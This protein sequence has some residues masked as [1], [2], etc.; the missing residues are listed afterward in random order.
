MHAA[1]VDPSRVVSKLVSEL[2]L[3]RGDQVS[4]FHDSAS[5]LRT[6]KD[7]P[8]IDVL[9]TSLEVQPIGGLELCWETRMAMPTQRPFYIIVMSSL[10]DDK[11]L[12]EAL[13]CGADDLIAKPV[14]KLELHARLRLAARLSSAQR[15]LVHL[16]DT[17]SLTSLLNRRAFF[18][19]LNGDLRDRQKAPKVSAILFDIDHFKRINDTYGH[20]VGDE[21]IRRIAAEGARYGQIAGRLGGEEFAIIV[22]KK[23]EATTLQLAEELRRAC[24]RLSFRGN[25]EAFHTTCSFGVS[26]WSDGDTVDS[27]LKRADVALYQAKTGGRNRVQLSGA[28]IV[29]D[30]PEYGIIRHRPRNES[31]GEKT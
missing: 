24:S 4:E 2:I 15:H 30:A 8:S 19:R 29:A 22:H 13:D 26:R 23:N 9:I 3:Q 17:D 18:E 11:K 31:G 28:S 27:L 20:D 5:A 14:R 21:V 25:G 7:D 10:S 1:V 6:I 16:A 12:A